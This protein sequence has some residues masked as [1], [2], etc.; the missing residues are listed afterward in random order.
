LK[1]KVLLIDVQVFIQIW[2]K[3]SVFWNNLGARRYCTERT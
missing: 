2:Q 3:G 1:F